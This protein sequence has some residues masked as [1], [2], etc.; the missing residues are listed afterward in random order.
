M[1]QRVKVLFS[2]QLCVS[3]PTWIR[4]HCSAWANEVERDAGRQ[5]H[6]RW[7][8]RV[9]DID[10]LLYDQ[11]VWETQGLTVPHPRMAVRRFVLDPAVE[12]A[13]DMIHAPTRQT[14]SRLLE[15]LN[16][17][18]RY[19][20]IA[21]ARHVLREQLAL[22]AGERLGAQV[23]LAGMAVDVNHDLREPMQ[24]EAA[25]PTDRMLRQAL[26]TLSRQQEL[27]RRVPE[28]AQAT[29]SLSDFWLNQVFVVASR[30]PQGTL[31]SRLEEACHEAL[32]TA[33]EPK[34]VLLLD[35][36]ATGSL[37]G[38]TEPTTTGVPE[39]GQGAFGV[40]ATPDRQLM[41]TAGSVPIVRASQDLE[42]AL[43]ELL[44]TVD[45]IG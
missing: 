41:D 16:E 25:R 21:G 12:I 38:G 34:F 15:R 4:K 22:A 45:A 35:T 20:A 33:P 32:A 36:A 5:R 40:Q 43:S 31:R 42:Q 19:M 24:L 8:P 11:L 17:P 6:E 37:K 10:L 28:S 9:I 7:G 18:P 26:D 3:Q 30:W 2:T 23:V 44:A 14:L 1:G 39:S 29:W 27:L 13:S